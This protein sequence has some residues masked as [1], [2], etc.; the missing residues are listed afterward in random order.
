[1]T[2]FFFFYQFKGITGWLPLVRK[3]SQ[4][5]FLS[6][7]LPVLLPAHC[8][9]QPLQ[10]LTLVRDGVGARGKFYVTLI[11]SWHSIVWAHEMLQLTSLPLGN[12]R[13]SDMCAVFSL[14]DY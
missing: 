7:L 14:A 8:C 1:M 10:D 2:L 11:M 13:F 6:V 3:S 5:G 12:L 4:L 9:F